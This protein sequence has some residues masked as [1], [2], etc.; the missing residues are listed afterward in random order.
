MQ[1][2]KKQLETTLINYFKKNFPEFP[3]GALTSSESPDFILTFKNRHQLGIEL[4]RLNPGNADPPGI[5]ELQKNDARDQLILQVKQLVEKDLPH[6]LFAKFL[7][8]DT[9]PIP[10]EKEMITAVKAAGAIRKAIERKK[11]DN[12]F[13]ISLNA[14]GLPE[15]IPEILLV[16]YPV[17]EKSVWERANNLGISNDVLGDIL[18]AI[19]KKEEKLKLYQKQRLNYYWLIIFTDRLRGVKNFNLHNKISNYSFTSRFQHVYLFDLMKAQV[20]ELV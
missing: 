1:P 3:K 16:N 19:I 7:F 15:G 9:Q 13:R 8:S 12:F 5:S 14:S 10:A 11:K 2:Y 4:T 17:L 18:K 6:R 20:F